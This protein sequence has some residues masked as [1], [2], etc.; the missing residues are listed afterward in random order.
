MLR[1]VMASVDE[2][3]ANVDELIKFAVERTPYA[4]IEAQKSLQHFRTVRQR[5]LRIAGLAAKCFFVDLLHFR[6]GR[7]HL[8][9]IDA[10]QGILSIRR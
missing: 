4:G 3:N 6:T 7:V 8:D 2:G 10:R 9:K 1:A 5:F